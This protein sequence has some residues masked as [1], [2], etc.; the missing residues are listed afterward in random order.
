MQ[1]QTHLM[2]GWC[3]ASWSDLDARERFFAMIAA[4]AADVDGLG[5]IVS[6]DAYAAYHHVLAHNLPFGV[7]VSAL[8]A[9]Y[10]THR[11]KAFWLYLGLFHLHLI[12]DYFG[13]G[14]GW[15]IDYFWPFSRWKIINPYAWEFASWQNFCAA[16]F[17]LLWTI[18]IAFRA[19]RTP[20]E[21]PM[22]ELDRKI[23][24]RLRRSRR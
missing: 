1:V 2:S 15:G 12:L 21:F 17:F 18:I 8:L 5:I 11:K 13:S 4:S 19:G 9:A 23:V 16:A 14:P 3:V 24:R 22:P 7:V 10:S 20:L 6:Y